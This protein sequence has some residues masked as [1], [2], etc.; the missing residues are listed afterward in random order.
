MFH[1]S[2]PV[3]RFQECLEFYVRCFG[4]E[5]VMLNE[6]AANIFAFG[7]QITFHDKQATA[8]SEE[9]RK[10]MHF[11]QVVSPEQWHQVR[12]ALISQGHQLLKQ[13]EPGSTASGRGKLVVKDPSGN[14]IEINSHAPL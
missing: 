12:D 9:G 13:D 8:L 4:A 10:Q 5:V 6:R 14:L 1:L 3:D 2:L 11:G 7:G